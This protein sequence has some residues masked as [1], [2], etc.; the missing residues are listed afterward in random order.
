MQA[1]LLTVMDSYGEDNVRVFVIGDNDESLASFQG[2]L[3][4]LFPKA[5]R[6]TK[7]R[8]E[9]HQLSDDDVRTSKFIFV[10]PYSPRQ[11]IYDESH[12]ARSFH[13]EID[14]AEFGGSTASNTSPGRDSGWYHVKC[15][16]SRMSP[17]YILL[18]LQFLLLFTGREI[19][20]VAV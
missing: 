8:S 2:T 4:R 14:R 17:Q 6:S 5:I 13:K 18:L 16:K 10:M 15:E 12:P 7:Q 11:I 20:I 9:F 3:R 1:R 19:L